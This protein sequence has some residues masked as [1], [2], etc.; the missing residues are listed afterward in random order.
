MTSNNISPSSGCSGL[1]N[2][3]ESGLKLRIRQ[4]CSRSQWCCSHRSLHSRALLRFFIRR[5]QEVS[6]VFLKDLI[7]QLQ[8]ERSTLGRPMVPPVPSVLSPL[9]VSKIKA[10]AKMET[11]QLLSPGHKDQDNF[12]QVPALSF[13]GVRPSMQ[14]CFGL[15]FGSQLIQA[16]ED[17]SSIF[18][19]VQYL[20]SIFEVTSWHCYSLSSLTSQRFL[21]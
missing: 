4:W 14:G 20:L 8:L 13:M 17:T 1:C 7:A 18:K 3:I 6:D 16:H 19:Y 11:N 21:L 15:S 2:F 10:D 12:L 5:Y 9:P